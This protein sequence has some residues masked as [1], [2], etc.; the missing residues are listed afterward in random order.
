[1]CPEVAGRCRAWIG[2]LFGNYHGEFFLE[3]GLCLESRGHTQADRGRASA[4]GVA[5]PSLMVVGEF[6]SQEQE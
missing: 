1:M 5:H 2:L 4:R 3:V 6:Q